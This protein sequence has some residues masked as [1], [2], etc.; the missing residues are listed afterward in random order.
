MKRR[1]EGHSPVPWSLLYVPLALPVLA[2]AFFRIGG[3]VLVAPL[4]A[5][6]AMPVRLRAALVF[7]LALVAFPMVQA[8]APAELSLSA[9][10]AG[11]VG[12]A[13]VGLTIGTVFMLMTNAM[14][15]AGAFVSHQSGLALGEVA[16]PALDQESD[17]VGQLYAII[18]LLAFL[19]IGG[20]RAMIRAL[21]DTYEMVP[22]L[23]FTADESVV[24]LIVEV[25]TAGFVLAIRLAA[26]VI[27]ALLLTTL[28]LGFISRT[29]P[30]LNILSVGFSLKSVVML[31]TAGVAL[32]ASQDLLV[33]GATDA[34]D[35]I[36]AH[37]A[38]PDNP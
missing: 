17:L 38:L 5:S 10:L 31:A 25:L 29:M 15:V 24:V 4:F 26:P 32:A 2:L 28:A 30:Q 23:S 21:L 37:F 1:E 12:E 9:A 11:G 7:V 13:L 22:V 27:I 19:A 33:S 16:N 20:H 36:R 14:E 34:V 18:M 3:M 6:N 35:A 8:Q